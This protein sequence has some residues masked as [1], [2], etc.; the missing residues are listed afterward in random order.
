[1]QSQELGK[2][3]QIN[4]AIYIVS[5][6]KFMLE[7]TLFLSTGMAAL[8]M[9]RRDSVDVDYEYDLDLADWLLMRQL[10]QRPTSEMDN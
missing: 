10:A 3:Y 4:G 9:D 2:S 5:V 7:Q 8:I 1:M 6:E